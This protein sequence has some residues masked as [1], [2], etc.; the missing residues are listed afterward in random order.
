MSNAV[1]FGK[2][3]VFSPSKFPI[4]LKILFVGDAVENKKSE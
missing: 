3:A 1:V 4:R 2:N